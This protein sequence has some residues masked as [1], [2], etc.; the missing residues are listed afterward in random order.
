MMTGKE[1]ARQSGHVFEIGTVN[2]VRYYTG[3]AVAH[4]LGHLTDDRL[5]AM[6]DKSL[7]RLAYRGDA[8]C[9]E[10]YCRS[11]KTGEVEDHCPHRAV[12]VLAFRRAQKE[13]ADQA[14]LERY[15]VNRSEATGT[16]AALIDTLSESGLISTVKDSRTSFRAMLVGLK[17]FCEANPGAEK[18]RELYSKQVNEYK[19][20]YAPQ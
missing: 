14:N 9:T 12:F 15:G 11:G 19:R 10:A 13:N 2:G 17:G 1:E 18:A 16:H 7:E 5:R 4:R 3:E 6:D 8:A 20:R